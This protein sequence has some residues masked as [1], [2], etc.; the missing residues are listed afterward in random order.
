VALGCEGADW[1]GYYGLLPCAGDDEALERYPRFHGQLDGHFSSRAF[2]QSR[3]PIASNW[4]A[5]QV[6]SDEK[7]GTHSLSLSFFFSFLSFLAARHH[8]ARAHACTSVIPPV[9]PFLFTNSC[10]LALGGRRV[11]YC[12]SANCFNNVMNHGMTPCAVNVCARARE[13][14]RERDNRRLLLFSCAI[15]ISNMNRALPGAGCVTSRFPQ[16]VRVNASRQRLEPKMANC[17]NIIINEPLPLDRRKSRGKLL[18]RMRDHIQYAPTGTRKAS[19]DRIRETR[20][21]SAGCELRTTLSSKRREER[22]RKRKE[23]KL[24]DIVEHVGCCRNRNRESES[25]S[26][27]CT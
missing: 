24:R 23:K 22:E 14:E 18:N 16:L 19:S 20:I 4:T 8:L 5:V 3:F 17:I 2:R 26:R 21:R 12:D 13:R 1:Q 9:M 7:R 27:A 6:R 10:T 25:V 15:T 11:R